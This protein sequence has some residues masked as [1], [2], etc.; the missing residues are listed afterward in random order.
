M[1]SLLVVRAVVPQPRSRGPHAACPLLGA[2]SSQAGR[3]RRVRV[4]NGTD[5]P[6]VG[7]SSATACRPEKGAWLRR[8]L[9]E[10]VRLRLRAPNIIR[11]NRIRRG[12]MQRAAITAQPIPWK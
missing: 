6:V 7:P 8:P 3:K 10:Q 5:R 9:V 4:K 1:I 11:S 12:Q 2:I